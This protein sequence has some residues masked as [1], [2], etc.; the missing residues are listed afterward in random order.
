MTLMIWEEPVAR[1]V[2]DW[3]HPHER[4][5]IQQDISFG[6]NGIISSGT[7]PNYLYTFTG[8]IDKGN[9]TDTS[10][11]VWNETQRSSWIDLIVHTP[12][13]NC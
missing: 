4:V 12:R 9:K 11:G 6:K 5:S 7:R 2:P 8:S 10:I 13:R 3:A 1:T